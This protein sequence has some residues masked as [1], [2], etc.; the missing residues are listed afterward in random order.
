MDAEGVGRPSTLAS[1][2]KS[3]LDKG[4]MER[5]KGKK[6]GFVATPLGLKVSDYLEP[7]FKDF[8][9]NEKYTSMLEDDLNK[10]ADGDKT[11][12]GVVEEVYQI[13]QQHIK[14]A[15]E[16]VPEREV[17]STGVKCTKCDDGE[18]V[19][20]SGRFGKFFS[21]DKYPNCKTVYVK[22]EDGNFTVK[23]KAVAKKTGRKCPECEKAGR[24]GELLERK[25]K[26]NG[27][28]FLGCS[29]YPKCKYSE[30][31]EE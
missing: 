20:K 29:A 21:C 24:N 17:N 14:D 30:S 2:V 13:L 22:D 11:F 3:L 4:Y 6:G 7:R 23:Q 10:I 9:M 5:E 12:L 25:N 1:I 16:N 28:K 8:F 15:K 31:I 26:K 27:E 19:E 18:I